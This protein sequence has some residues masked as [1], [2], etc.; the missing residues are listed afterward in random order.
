MR[1]AILSLQSW[2]LQ[3]QEPS[4]SLSLLDQAESHLGPSPEPAIAAL[5]LSTRAWRH[6][7]NRQADPTHATLAM[8]DLDNAESHLSRIDPADSSLYIFESAKGEAIERRSLALLYMG[9]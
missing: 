3:D 2:R 6:A 4:L 7:K 9:H 1:S 8:R 5:V